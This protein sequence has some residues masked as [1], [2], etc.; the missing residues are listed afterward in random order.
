MLGHH[1]TKSNP[2]PSGSQ[3]HTHNAS[4]AEASKRLIASESMQDLYKRT[5]N[6]PGSCDV[7]SPHESPSGTPPPPYRGLV[8]K[9]PIIHYIIFVFHGKTHRHFFLADDGNEE[10][11]QLRSYGDHTPDVS[12]LRGSIGPHASTPIGQSI[13]SMEDDDT[14]DQE[15]VSIRDFLICK[16]F[17]IFVIYRE[18]SFTASFRRSWAF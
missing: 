5:K 8:G 3:T 12:P 7:D 18:E 2:D 16:F 9:F 11:V 6:H 10:D 1:R 4:M 15:L 14:S 17:E 13:I